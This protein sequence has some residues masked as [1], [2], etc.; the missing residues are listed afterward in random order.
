MGRCIERCAREREA[1]ERKAREREADAREGSGGRVS[2]KTIAGYA[3][4]SVTVVV[5]T[6]STAA[7]G[8]VRLHH[9]H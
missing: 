6:F 5:V 2:Q 3:E 8:I 4:S 1:R 9:G 7:V